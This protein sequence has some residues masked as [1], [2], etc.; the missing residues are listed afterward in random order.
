[1]VKPRLLRL[2]TSA[3]VALSVL[4]P[5]WRATPTFPEGSQ[6]TT[7]GYAFLLS[8]PGSICPHWD[9]YATNPH[10]D[11]ER[12][13]LEWVGIAALAGMAR[14]VRPEWW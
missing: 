1:M 12:L 3:L 13:A 10:I 4:F 2:T 9:Y 11:L 8:G 14:L 6:A 5:P 7:C